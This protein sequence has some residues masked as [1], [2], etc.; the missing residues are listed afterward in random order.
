MSNY[1]R[2]KLGCNKPHSTN[3][4][5]VLHQ[6]METEDV[7]KIFDPVIDRIVDLVKQQVRDV[8]RKGE[9]VAVCYIL[10]IIR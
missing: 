8:E 10:H 3:S 6:L 7:Q 1:S 2:H 5:D 4:Q 9:N